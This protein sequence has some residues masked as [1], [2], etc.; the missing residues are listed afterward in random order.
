MIHSLFYHCN[1][2][3]EMCS[4]SI[5]FFPLFFFS[6][7]SRLLLLRRWW[8]RRAAGMWLFCNKATRCCAFMHDALFLSFMIL[9]PDI[10]RVMQGICELA[11]E[12]L[13]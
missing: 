6:F 3:H 11:I 7:S 5:S 12:A 1:E 8:Q 9:F 2:I 4:R 13:G 10:Y